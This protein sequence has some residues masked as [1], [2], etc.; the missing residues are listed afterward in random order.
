MT[1]SNDDN[2]VRLVLAHEFFRCDQAFL[3]FAELAVVNIGGKSNK[4]M[5]LKMFD[6][7]SRFLHHLYEFY[8]GVMKLP[9]NRERFKDG[10]DHAIQTELERA[11][12]VRADRIRAGRASKHENDLAYYEKRIPKEFARCFR[13]ARNRVAHA[14][15]K[16]TGIGDSL[17][18]PQFYNNYHRYVILL[19]EE[20]ECLWKVDF[21]NFDWGE[22][23]AFDLAVHAK[24]VPGHRLTGF[25]AHL[26][27]WIFERKLMAA[28]RSQR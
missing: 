28:I 14:D 2:A 19:H 21:D 13:E 20:A 6:A 18:L 3:D 1:S 22:I 4:R 26:K 23:E 9:H 27:N 5:R 12:R 11:M 16:R 17:T 15:P 25:L 10:R 8:V 7:Y 24:N